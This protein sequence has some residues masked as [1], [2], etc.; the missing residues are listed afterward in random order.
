MTAPLMPKATAVW[1]VDNTALSFDQIADFCGLHALEVQAIADEEVAIGMQGLDPIANG[2][3]TRE[4]IS[5]CEGDTAER[6]KL[7]T[8]DNPMPEARSKGPRYTPL[9][10]RQDKPDAVAWLLRHYP[11]LSDAQVGRLI[12]TTKPTINSIR[13]RT[14]WNSPNLRPRSPVEIGLCTMD[15]LESNLETARK[16]AARKAERERKAAEKAAREKAAAAD[17]A[18]EA[19]TPEPAA[20]E[21]A[22]APETPAWPPA[23]DAGADEAPATAGATQSTEPDNASETVAETPAWPPSAPSAEDEKD[24]A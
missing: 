8:S 7:L 15:E 18:A 23:P 11:E 19:A 12:G 17:A 13:D 21:E 22:A 6:L 16:R 1:L 14:H 3:L 9:S 4:E 20:S 24:P 10:K 5:R 2:Q